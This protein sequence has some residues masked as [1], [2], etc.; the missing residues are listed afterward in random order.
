MLL[1]RCAPCP[2]RL[3]AAPSWLWTW[4]AGRGK[5]RPSWQ[6][7]SQRWWAPTSARH[8]SKRPGLPLL[9]PTSPICEC[10]RQN[11]APRVPFSFVSRSAI[12]SIA[13]C[14]FSP[15]VCRVCPAEE[16]PFEDA[17]VDLLASFTAAHWFDTGK[18]MNEAKR[19]LR[20]GGCVA[21]ST[22]T[23]DMSL[24]YGDCSEKLTQIF[25]EVREGTEPPHWGRGK[26]TVVGGC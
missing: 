26:H 9:L 14:Y 10:C 1:L 2:C 23:A 20:P 21:I 13:H 15:P 11:P 22:Y 12:P 18:F 3:P 25:R 6:S 19:V 7:A 17:S 5:A 24:H 8:R 4:A 16:L